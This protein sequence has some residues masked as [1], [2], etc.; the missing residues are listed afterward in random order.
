MASP[1][2][3]DSTPLVVLASNTVTATG[4]SASFTLPQ[5]E[6]YALYL[7]ASAASGTTPV[8][9][10][11]LQTS[12][13]NGTTWVNTGVAFASVTAAGSNGVVFKP[14]MGIGQNAGVITV[15]PGT[16]SALNQPINRKFMRLS[17][18]VTGTTPSIT[19]TLYALAS[20]KG[21]SVV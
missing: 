11:V 9:N 7:V 1:N 16:A 17:N 18:T 14:T 8:L 21:A 3:Q 20:P 2:M 15:T 13:D 10:A 19:F 6:C 5:A 4:N 12:L